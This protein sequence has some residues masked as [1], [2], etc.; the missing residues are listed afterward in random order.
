MQKN[1]I[2]LLTLRW[3]II[4]DSLR[5]IALAKKL[6][7]EYNS[8]NIF[9][10]CWK[11][12]FDL[13][14]NNKYIKPIYIKELNYLSDSNINIFKKII[15]LFIAF[16]KI[17]YLTKNINLIH[18]SWQK[19]I[20]RYN[21]AKIL[22]FLKK[23]KF[24]HYWFEEAKWYI[25]ELNF[26]I[27]KQ[28]IIN[29]FLIKNNKKN[30]VINIESQELKRCWSIKNYSQL[31]KKLGEKYNIYLV[32]LNEEYNKYIITNNNVVNLVWK[33]NILETS[34]IIENS[35]LYIWND[36][37]IAHLSYILWTDTLIVINKENSTNKN[38]IFNKKGVTVKIIESPNIE[39]I[40]SEI[41]L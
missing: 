24:Q 19:N 15:Y 18:Y 4:W 14:K 25:P 32:W 21:L 16:F 41:K 5:E 3:N 11:I 22:S 27:N 2:L 40:I 7:K 37:W 28:D 33:T 23:S 13:L 8:N 36:S 39:K 30:I 12:I 10:P 29:E 9:Y 38:K 34:I 6:I 31:I 1:N 20:L 26:N 35:N 17:I